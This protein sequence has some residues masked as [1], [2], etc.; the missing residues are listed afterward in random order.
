MWTKE[1][2]KRVIAAYG[3]SGHML[4]KMP[5]AM[6]LLCCHTIMLMVL[7]DKG[8]IRS[9]GGPTLMEEFALRVLSK[10]ADAYAI[11]IKPLLDNEVNRQRLILP[12]VVSP[13]NKEPV[14]RNGLLVRSQRYAPVVADSARAQRFQS[15]PKRCLMYMADENNKIEHNYSNTLFVIPRYYTTDL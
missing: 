7:Q 11:H 10:D 5:P 2:R 3:P 1:L 8:N 13:A 4:K 9:H 6:A 15:F 12:S 14:T